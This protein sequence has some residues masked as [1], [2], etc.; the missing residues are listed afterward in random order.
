[1]FSIT[2]SSSSRRPSDRCSCQTRGWLGF[3]DIVL[4][5]LNVIFSCVISSLW[6]KLQLVQILNA[7]KTFLQLTCRHKDPLAPLAASHDQLKRLLHWLCWIDR[8]WYTNRLVAWPKD[9]RFHH[10]RPLSISTRRSRS[11]SKHVYL[12]GA[13]NG[14]HP[15]RAAFMN[16]KLYMQLSMNICPWIRVYI[17][18]PLP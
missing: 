11:K 10:C 5:S 4:L 13:L 17:E 18:G 14:M 8:S 16:Q 3:V 2:T 6:R 15:K 12:Y 9:W 7:S 1:M